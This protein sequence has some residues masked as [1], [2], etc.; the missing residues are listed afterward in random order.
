MVYHLQ[1]EVGLG[2]TLRFMRLPLDT[3]GVDSWVGAAFVLAT[4]LGLFE[5]T[6]RSFVREWG[7]IHTEMAQSTALRE[8]AE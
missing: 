7:E 5:L 3:H 1:L 2:S 8:A 6:R 4:G